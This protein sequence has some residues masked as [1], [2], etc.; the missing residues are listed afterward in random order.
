MKRFSPILQTFGVAS[1]S[2]NFHEQFLDAFSIHCGK[3]KMNEDYK[4]H[5]IWAAGLKESQVT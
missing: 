4:G 5:E 3:I 1:P 2:P